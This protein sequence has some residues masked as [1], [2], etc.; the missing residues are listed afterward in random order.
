MRERDRD[1]ERQ[2]ERDRDRERQ[3]ET[4]TERQRDRERQR[5]WRE[6]REEGKRETLIVQQGCVQCQSSCPDGFTQQTDS[7]VYTFSFFMAS[8]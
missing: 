7:I 8:S 3:R 1:R 6:W 4:E 2:T 5:E